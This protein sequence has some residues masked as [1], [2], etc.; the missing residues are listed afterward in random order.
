MINTGDATAADL[1]KLGE[2]VIKRVFKSTGLTLRW[3]I[4][5]VGEPAE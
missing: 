5:R 4:K 3:E 1:E 2:E